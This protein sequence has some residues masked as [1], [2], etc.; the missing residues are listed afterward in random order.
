MRCAPMM[1]LEFMGSMIA[2]VMKADKTSNG[3][4]GGA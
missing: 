1:W 4:H 2:Q 3:L